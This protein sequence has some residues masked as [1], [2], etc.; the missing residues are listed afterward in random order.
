MIFVNNIN[1]KSINKD[2]PYL[3]KKKVLIT[4]SKYTYITCMSEIKGS[5]ERYSHSSLLN[6]NAI[7]ACNTLMSRYEG[8]IKILYTV[9]KKVLSR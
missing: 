9:G 3:P 6:S 4:I 2:I 7:Y 5:Y 8:N 1:V